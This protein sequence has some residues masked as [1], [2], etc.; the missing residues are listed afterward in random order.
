[1]ATVFAME[2]V[3]RKRIDMIFEMKP[4]TAE[5]TKM[6]SGETEIIP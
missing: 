6:G 2:S 4:G 3:M 5:T 1:V